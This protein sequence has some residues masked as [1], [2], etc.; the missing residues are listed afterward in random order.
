MIRDDHL[1]D[2]MQRYHFSIAGMRTL[3]GGSAPWHNS[4]DGSL[5][6]DPS[7]RWRE[8]VLQ[9]RRELTCE[10]CG[11]TFAYTFTVVEEGHVYRGQYTPGYEELAHALG[12]ELRRRVHCP[13]CRAVQRETRRAFVRRERQHTLIGSVAM[14]GG[15]LGATV[16]IFGGYALAGMWGLALGAIVAMGLVISLT[17]WMLARVL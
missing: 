17:Q 1:T 12:H 7:G 10:Q 9:V 6:F 8:V 15:I 14:G 16:C 13:F 4:A 5:A 2:L 3:G 11:E